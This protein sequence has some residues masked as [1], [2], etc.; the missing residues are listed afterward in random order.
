M[1][2]LCGAEDG[3]EEVTVSVERRMARFLGFRK[4]WLQLPLVGFVDDGDMRE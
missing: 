1:S 2:G 3:A 4:A